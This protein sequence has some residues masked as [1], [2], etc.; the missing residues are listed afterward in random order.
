MKRICPSN[1]YKLFFDY[2]IGE[3]LHVICDKLPGYCVRDQK[4]FYDLGEKFEEY[5]DSANHHMSNPRLDRHKLASCI[6][7]AVIELQPIVGAD[8]AQVPRANSLFALHVGLNVI[9][10]YMIYD[11]VK[12][13]EISSSSKERMKVYLKEHFDMAMPAVDENIC[14]TQEY[15]MNLLNAL[16]RTHHR[17]SF[18]RKECYHYDIWAYAKIFYHLELYNRPRFEKVL[19]E[20]REDEEAGAVALS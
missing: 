18:K 1:T 5:R 13:L 3:L 15:Q 9:K 10:F 20:Y 8:G 2:I 11:W 16:C 6:C 14:D 12:E 4:V 17:C 7:G 19:T